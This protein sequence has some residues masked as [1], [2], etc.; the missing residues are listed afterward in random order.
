MSG[1]NAVSNSSQLQLNS[2]NNNNNNSPY[3]SGDPYYAASTGYIAPTSRQKSGASKWIKI[4]IPV[5]II[6]IAA[7]V[8]GGILGSRAHH[9]SASTLAASPNTPAGASQAVSAKNAIGRFATATNSEYML[10]IYPATVS[11]TYLFASFFVS[12]AHHTHFLI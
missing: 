7:A 5:A 3:G 4:G 1:Y 10:P 6:V 8:V 12:H 2:Y 11:R 9:N